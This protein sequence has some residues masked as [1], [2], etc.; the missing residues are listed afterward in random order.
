MRCLNC[1]QEYNEIYEV[2]P[3]CGYIRG[4]KPQEPYH[5]HPGMELLGKYVIGTVIGFGGFGVIYKAWDKNFEK[6]VAVKEYYPTT[7]LSRNVGEKQ[8]YIYDKRNVEEFEKG[9]KEFLEEARNLAK[10]NNHPN[11]VHVYDFFEENGT[12]Y[13]VMEF[14]D[15]CNLKTFLQVNAQSGR[16]I[17]VE[18]A[19]QITQCVLSALKAV[20]A[21]KIIHRDIKPGNIF[22]CKD[23]TIKLIDLGAARFSDSEME[24]TRTIIITPGYAPAEQYQIKSKQG[25]YTDIYAVAA[26]LY[27][28]LTGIKPDESINRKVEDTLIEPQ[29]MN[30]D[31]PANINSAVMRAMAIQSEIRFQNVDQFAKALRSEKEVRDAKREIK[32]RKRRR[33][34]RIAVLAAIVICA[35][36]FCYQQYINV[37]KEA[38]LE[39][40]ELEV[41]IPYEEE[42][43]EAA[44]QLM[45]NMT[46]EYLQNNEMIKLDIKAIA[47]ED[48]ETELRTALEKGNAPDI[49]DSSCLGTE[50][51]EKLADLNK[52]FDF[53][54][55]EEEQYYFLDQYENYFP[56]A[57]QLPLTVNV[58]IY[59]TNSIWNEEVSGEENVS[60]TREQ[61][62]N[63]TIGEYLGSIEDYSEI[64]NNLS[65]IYSLS[66]PDISQGSSSDSEVGNF[67]N[68]WSINVASTEEEYAAAIRLMYY[69]LSETAQDYLAVQNDNNLPLNRNILDVYIDV[70]SDFEKLK[71]YLQVVVVNGE[72]K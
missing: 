71:E 53:E 25:P 48:Y 6:V 21:S 9:K 20:H 7:F 47:K 62:L 36:L 54:L 33:G 15:G 46:A 68:L 10:F 13:F 49:F 45:D 34:I 55:F 65:G 24:K 38:I 51:Y 1:M 60:G 31:V 56:S 26:V 50:D 64:Q 41:W 11:I 8:A 28:M 3:H 17:S 69:L 4:T 2:C 63:Q 52:L 14:L 12:A 18:T 70:N 35:G 27:E 72:S 61:F 30:P 40:A 22:I 32:Y 58:P 44:V 42:S 37:R 66:Y 57:K 29:K 59:Y 5:L 16:R 67:S 23:G 19:L 43:E 39:P